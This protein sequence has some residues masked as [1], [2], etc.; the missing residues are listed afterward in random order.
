MTVFLNVLKQ[1]LWLKNRANSILNFTVYNL[2]KCVCVCVCVLWLFVQ[3]PNSYSKL[4]LNLYFLS[5][6]RSERNRRGLSMSATSLYLTI[7]RT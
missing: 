6:C 7:L 5:C 3:N 2:C 1:L 4:T